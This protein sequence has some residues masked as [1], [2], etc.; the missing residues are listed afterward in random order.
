LESA[1]LI[2]VGQA[3][4]AKLEVQKLVLV[5]VGMLVVS[6]VSVSSSCVLG[7]LFDEFKGVGVFVTVLKT[8][9]FVTVLKT[10]VFVTVFSFLSMLQGV[11]IMMAAV[12][13]RVFQL[14]LNAIV[15]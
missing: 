6:V 1:A 10:S 4:F 8:S 9:I 14:N 13:T 2:P 3:T 7:I 12:A 5:V 15:L 11:L